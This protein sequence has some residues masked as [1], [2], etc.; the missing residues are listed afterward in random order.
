MLQNRHDM[1]ILYSINTLVSKQYEV[2]VKFTAQIIESSESQR[3]I[4]CTE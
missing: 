2:Y 3:D 4:A 1:N